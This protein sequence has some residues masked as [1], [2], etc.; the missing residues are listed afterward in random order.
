MNVLSTS[1]TNLTKL[2][3]SFARL[4]SASKSGMTSKKAKAQTEE[5]DKLLNVDRYD[6]EL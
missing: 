2:L 1:N 6:D 4:I 3:D 5:L